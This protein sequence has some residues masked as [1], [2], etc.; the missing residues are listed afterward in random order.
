ML[1]MLCV[2]LTALIQTTTITTKKLLLWRWQWQT[3]WSVGFSILSTP[4]SIWSYVAMITCNRVCTQ[5]LGLLQAPGLPL[6]PLPPPEELSHHHFHPKL[7]NSKFGERRSRWMASFIT[8]SA[9]LL[10]LSRWKGEGGNGA[11]FLSISN[12]VTRAARA[13]P[14]QQANKARSAT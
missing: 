9:S 14:S 12:W 13:R 8:K 2:L 4:W 11:F 10:H 3:G 7:L 1:W 5:Q 6:L